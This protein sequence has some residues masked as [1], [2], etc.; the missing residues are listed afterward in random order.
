[1]VIIFLKTRHFTYWGYASSSECLM[2]NFLSTI[3][4]DNTKK[5]NTQI[6]R[7]LEREALFS[8]INV[9]EYGNEEFH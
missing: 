1:M 2:A 7:F 3:G 6:D 9:L 4:L 8:K 5:V